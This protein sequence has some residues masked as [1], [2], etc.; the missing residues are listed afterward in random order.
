MAEVAS[1]GSKAPI[2]SSSVGR[3]PASEDAEYRT[4]LKLYNARSF[5]KESSR[6]NSSGELKSVLNKEEVTYVLR[7]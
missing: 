7:N 4:I 2:Q 1:V 5:I 6:V 3:L